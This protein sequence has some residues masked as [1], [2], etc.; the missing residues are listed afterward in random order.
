MTQYERMLKGLPYHGDEE[1]RGIMMRTK[2]LT[3]EYN[4]L[5]PDKL[6]RREEILKE[7]LG[8]TGEKIHIEQPFHC[9]YGCNIEVGE[10]FYANY[11]LTVLDCN[12]VVFGDNCM[13][14]PNV[15][16]TT[17][18]HPVHPVSRTKNWYEYA[19]PVT[20]GNNV[21]LGANVVVCPGVTIG[22]GSV[23]GAG[24]VVTRD[25]PANVVAF[26]NPCRVYREITEED[27]HLYYKDR[28]FDV[29]DY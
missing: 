5:S 27:R 16:I 11:N 10:N 2:L 19:I 6:E 9:D 18:G 17:A 14:A 15:M 20:I 29:D 1:I 25:I 23:I 26:G 7:L 3:H 24:S 13:C 21:W 22:D 28:P 12:K 4:M 8:K